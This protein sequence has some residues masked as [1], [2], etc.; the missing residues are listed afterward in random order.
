MLVANHSD[1]YS[2]NLNPEPLHS[3]LLFPASSL[4]SR[5]VTIAHPMGSPDCREL[6]GGFPKIGDPNIVP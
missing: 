2:T 1:P 3:D 6:I 5:R 4:S